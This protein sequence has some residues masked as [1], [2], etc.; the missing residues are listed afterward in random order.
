MLEINAFADYISE[1]WS[2]WGHVQTLTA[3]A[4]LL[5]VSNELKG[6]WLCPQCHTQ[7]IIGPLPPVLSSKGTLS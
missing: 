4:S 2:L 7:Q 3:P 5:W 6:R 1:W